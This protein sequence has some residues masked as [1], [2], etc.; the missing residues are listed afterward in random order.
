MNT[1]RLWVIV[2][3]IAVLTPL[4]L[5]LPA[6]LG[7]GGAWGEWGADEVGRRLG[8][9]PR[10]MAKIT[11]LWGAPAPDYAPPGWE[12]RSFAHRSAAYMASA[13][14]GLIVIAALMLALGRL[15]SRREKAGA[16]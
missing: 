10:G 5:W 14:I 9:V 6:R 7:A 11:D 4:G 8:F 12:E 16:P 13:V 3:A 2:L 15:L 1:K